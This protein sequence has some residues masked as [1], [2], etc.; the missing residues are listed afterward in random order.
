M[1]Q[2][3]VNAGNPYDVDHVTELRDWTG[4]GHGNQESNLRILCHKVCHKLKT[5]LAKQARANSAR[6]RR[7]I[8][9]HKH[10][11][12]RN[13]RDG[14]LKTTFSYGTILRRAKANDVD[15]PD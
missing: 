7:A 6:T 2:Q 4:E 15:A 1:C 3:P 14:P 5:R 9:E 10:S 13:S 8:M 12:F 11:K